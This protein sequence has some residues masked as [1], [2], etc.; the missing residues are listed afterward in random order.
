MTWTAKT[1]A[2]SSLSDGD[3]GSGS[4]I[5]S[6]ETVV[7][8]DFLPTVMEILKV[9]RPSN[10]RHWAMDGRSILNLLKNPL[11]F[12]WDDTSDGPRA[13]GIGY[14]HAQIPKMIG[15][16]VRVV[17]ENI[18]HIAKKKHSKTKNICS[19]LKC[20]FLIEKDF[21]MF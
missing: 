18:L 11:E 20:I 2:S 17:N 9:D 10:Q 1:T 5:E 19:E 14:Y 12:K 7:T 3:G 4:S 13:I 16:Y 15:W 6:W 21:V 8:M